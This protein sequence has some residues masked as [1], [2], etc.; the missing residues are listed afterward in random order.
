MP[1]PVAL[2][3][4][5]MLRD[6]DHPT[7]S[8]AL[9]EHGPVS[10]ERLGSSGDPKSGRMPQRAPV[11]AALEPKGIRIGDPVAA[12]QRERRLVERPAV[13]LRPPATATSRRHQPV[14]QLVQERQP[15]VHEIGAG[16]DRHVVA[17]APGQA[18]RC[19]AGP[20]SPA[21]HG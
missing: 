19:I 18:R 6:S 9:A 8:W 11:P 7:P 10:G 21:Q 13:V 2:Q 20:P 4:D 14:G 16:P 1:P 17:S 15:L 5:G 12:V 3:S